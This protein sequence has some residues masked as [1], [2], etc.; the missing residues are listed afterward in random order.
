MAALFALV[1]VALTLGTSAP[2]SAKPSVRLLRAS[3]AVVSGGGFVGR[4]RVTVTVTRGATRLTTTVRADID[5]AFVVRFRRALAI[6]NCLRVTV[7]ADGADGD[8]AVWRS[9]PPACGAQP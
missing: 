8:R 5:G 7:R 4:E 6:A 3:P 9:P 2:T 1:V